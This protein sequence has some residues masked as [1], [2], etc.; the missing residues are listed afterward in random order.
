[1]V[2][3]SPP[4]C[5][6]L[7]MIGRCLNC[8]CSIFYASQLGTGGDARK[9][10]LVLREKAT[11]TVEPT[12]IFD[13]T[14]CFLPALNDFA[15]HGGALPD[16][17]VFLLIGTEKKLSDVDE[18]VPVYATVACKRA[19]DDLN[20]ISALLQVTTA[21]LYLSTPGNN[22]RSTCLLQVTSASLH[23]HV[24]LTS[25]CLSVFVVVLM[26]LVCWCY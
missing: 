10:P 26:S 8:R 22:C 11:D 16:P 24:I 12:V 21:S 19:M 25:V 20:S 6:V 18:T 5:V 15:L 9:L 4:P 7:G 2:S 1:M 23:V 3:P 17:R 13:Y 14:S